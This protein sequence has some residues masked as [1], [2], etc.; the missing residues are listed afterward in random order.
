M[1]SV[2]LPAHKESLW[3]EMNA[4]NRVLESSA[5]PTMI[6]LGKTGIA[7]PVGASPDYLVTRDHSGMS[8]ELSS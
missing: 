7:P 3:K 5:V 4:T 6:S 2:W 1:V 8:G